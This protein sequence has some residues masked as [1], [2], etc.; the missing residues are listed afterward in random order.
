MPQLTELDKKFIG[1]ILDGLADGLTIDYPWYL[2]DNDDNR[3][4]VIGV[5]WWAWGSEIYREEVKDP[6]KIETFRSEID[7]RDYIVTNIVIIREYLKTKL[8]GG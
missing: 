3:L 5:Q 8:I 4:F 7:K 6:G 2:P 1:N